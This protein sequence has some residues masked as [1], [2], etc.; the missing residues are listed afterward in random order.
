MK[1]TLCKAKVWLIPVLAVLALC[2]C[3]LAA[4][5]PTRANAEAPVYE[6]TGINGVVAATGTT[7]DAFYVNAS[8]V[9]ESVTG[10]WHIQYGGAL[11]RTARILRL[12]SEL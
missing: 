1:K 5:L 10:T 8:S 9:S 2:M 3:A 7:N 12:L 11:K 4:L 6:V